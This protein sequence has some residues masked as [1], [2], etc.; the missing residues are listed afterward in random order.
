L[1]FIQLIDSS[2]IY[3]AMHSMENKSFH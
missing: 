1:M 3:E 2:F